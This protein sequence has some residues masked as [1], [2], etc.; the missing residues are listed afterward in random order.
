MPLNLSVNSRFLFTPAS[1][2]H[3]TYLSTVFLKSYNDKLGVSF[4]CFNGL[5]LVQ[6]S[7][8]LKLE[9]GGVT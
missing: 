4:V 1:N 5:V 8:K 6:N 2:N 3:P 9:V 7:T